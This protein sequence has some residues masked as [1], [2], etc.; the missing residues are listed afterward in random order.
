MTATRH[1][2]HNVDAERSLLGAILLTREARDAAFA[3]VSAGDLYTP[4]HQLIYAAVEALAEEGQPVD[5]VTVADQLGRNGQLA[6][7]GGLV[8]LTDLVADCPAASNAAR[9]AAI[10]SEH[11]HRRRLL[12]A[13]LE[14]VEA[15]HDGSDPARY[16]DRLTS[17][18]TATAEQTS[19]WTAVELAP[20]LD[21]GHPEIQPEWL[22][23]ADGAPLLYPGRIHAFNGESE[24]GKAQPLDAFVATP[25]GWRQ[26][27]SL[28]VGDQVIG[29]AGP[30]TVT[31]IY[32]QGVQPIW[33]LGCSDGSS[34][35]CTGDHLWLTQNCNNR[36][37]GQKGTVL[38]TDEIR[39][40]LAERTG[41]N[42]SMYLPM[43][44]PVEHP[45]ADFLLDPYLLGVLIGD[46]GL[47]KDVVISSGDSEVFDQVRRVLPCGDTLHL[48]DSVTATIRGGFTRIALK[49]L[50]LHGCKSENKEIPA[51]YLR[52][53]ISQRIALLQGLMDTD[54][55]MEGSP[56][57]CTTSPVLAAQVRELVESLGGTAATHL[58]HPYYVYR[59]ERREGRKAY[60]V[61]VR[62]RRDLG[63]PFRIT[64]K[65]TAWARRMTRYTV[66]PVRR[67]V[68]VEPAGSK[69]A[70]CISV[71][72]PDCL[73]A[74][75]HYLLTHN[76]WL[77]LMA[78]MEALTAGRRSL[79]VDFEDR[80]DLFVE[81]L[82]LLGADPAA[83]VELVTYIR[84]DEP[85]D[86]TARVQLAGLLDTHDY[87]VAVLD[88]LAEALS[89]NGWEENSA[90]D[91]MAFYQ[92]LP[93]RIARAGAAVVIIDHLVKDK[94]NQG[95]YARGSTAKLAGIDGA[96]YKVETITP[97][98]R[99]MTGKSRLVLAKD[100]VGYVRQTAAGHKNIAEMVLASTSGRVQ[101]ELAVPAA[102]TAG[103]GGEYQPTIY[104]EKV[105]RALEPLD[106]PVTSAQLATI[107][108]GRA[109]MV[110]KAVAALVAGG[111]VQT[112]QKGSAA[113]LKSVRP[114]R[115]QPDPE[116][117]GPGIPPDYM[118]EGEE[119][120]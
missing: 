117:G 37:R 54:G 101:I 20:V 111:Y 32:P 63:C 41:R 33:R 17:E 84:P 68:S 67:I 60:V 62:L 85:F 58:K 79:T 77:G 107:V 90:K 94:E 119:P 57:L 49:R 24:S 27:G 91:V 56:T 55:G 10:V 61:T 92:A 73:Y 78:V 99:G 87:A 29:S 25:G 89:N 74:T 40:R 106:L 18:I 96:V 83:I 118:L 105:S 86:G 93:R 82:L 35:E 66:P 100:R 71:D 116:P 59:G 19:T 69:H 22:R 112:V 16:V 36:F 46:G 1:P 80:A 7:A 26:M 44:E 8:A 21:G 102:K 3:K 13:A 15:V 103:P 51:E 70:Q 88:G 65:V 104:M 120:Y 34:V 108:P 12:G 43:I 47:T 45:R 42:N 11:A 48:R 113:L 110:R 81:R 109:D 53:S 98:G 64:R 95:R 39:R 76:T 28:R 6:D 5:A 23:R 50:H 72:A 115:D 31:G 9:Y 114:F 52:G 30:V 4:S 75:E 2:P 97:F 14:I 38:T